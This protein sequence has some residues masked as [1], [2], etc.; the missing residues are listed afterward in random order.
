MVI[1]AAD[2]HADDGADRDRVG[3][4]RRD[5]APRRRDAAPRLSDFLAG[6]YSNEWKPLTPR[7]PHAAVDGY[8]KLPN[9]LPSDQALFRDE[10]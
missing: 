8:H 1:G 2:G 9:G 4:Q 7:A 3:A 5:A 6:E 10:L